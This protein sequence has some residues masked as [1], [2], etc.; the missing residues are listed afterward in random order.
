MAVPKR[1]KSK[2]KVRQ[3]KASKRCKPI[4][5]NH[6]KVC[7]APVKPHRICVACGNYKGKQVITV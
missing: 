2:M 4:Q 1:K 3:V 6:C 7:G 5:V